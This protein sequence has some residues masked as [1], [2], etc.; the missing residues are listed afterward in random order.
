MS[1]VIHHPEF[2]RQPPEW[3]PNGEGDSHRCQKTLVVAGVAVVEHQSTF[4]GRA[5]K[6]IKSLAIISRQAI[7]VTL[8]VL[9]ISR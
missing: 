1:P 5:G 4:I 8:P 2:Q 3:P 6:E 7:V 9:A